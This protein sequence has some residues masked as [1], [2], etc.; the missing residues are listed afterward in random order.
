MIGTLDVGASPRQTSR[1][2][3]V[4]QPDVEQ[5]EIGA[6][7]PAALEPVGD[8]VHDLG[9]EAVALERLGER[10][11]DRLLVLDQEDRPLR[12]RHGLSVPV[13]RAT[14][15]ARG[16]HGCRRLA[17]DEAAAHSLLAVI[18]D[19]HQNVYFTPRFSTAVRLAVPVSPRTR[20]FQV[21]PPPLSQKSWPSSEALRTR[22]FTVPGLRLRREP[23]RVADLG[24]ADRLRGARDHVE[25]V[26]R[27]HR[28]HRCCRGRRRPRL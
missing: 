18:A 7:R 19:E 16:G 13:R 25:Q 27:G 1:P 4:G 11:G 10:S 6:K 17:G 5:D 3:A 23:D 12:V 21:L 2:G 28:D 20:V 24:D 15:V 22:N 8:G 26:L 14:L 9:V